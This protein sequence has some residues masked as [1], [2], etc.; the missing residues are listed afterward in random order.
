MSKD[1]YEKKSCCKSYCNSY[2]TLYTRF[3]PHKDEL[4]ANLASEESEGMGTGRV[5]SQR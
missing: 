2:K 4:G 1:N 3:Q 5:L